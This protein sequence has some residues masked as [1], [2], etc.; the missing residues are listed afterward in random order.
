MAYNLSGSVDEPAKTDLMSGSTSKPDS[1]S[2]SAAASIEMDSFSGPTSKSE[3]SRGCLLQMRRQRQSQPISAGAI[4]VM[5]DKKIVFNH[6]TAAEKFAQEKY[7]SIKTARKNI[8]NRW[9][10][11]E[12]SV[13]AIAAKALED[14][15]R[16]A[17]AKSGS[18]DYDEQNLVYA[19]TNHF[20]IETRLFPLSMAY[21]KH[22]V[23]VN[24]HMA[25]EDW[26]ELQLSERRPARKGKRNR[27]IAIR[28]EANESVVGGW[29][30][31]STTNEESWEDLGITKEYE[32]V[33]WAV[34]LYNEKYREERSAISIGCY[35][36]SLLRWS[37]TVGE[38]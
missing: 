12:D 17:I 29:G 1:L 13:Y 9:Y 34:Q 18:L 26:I 7:K 27:D 11:I 21:E 31:G 25:Q 15:N 33:A 4:G 20:T 3:F 38:Q 10:E 5:E 35:K 28:V 37:L 14:L 2:V 32:P 19:V 30:W 6:W 22:S 36:P 16:I 8:A 23:T 24:M